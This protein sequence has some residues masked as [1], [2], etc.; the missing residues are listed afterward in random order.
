M[1]NIFSKRC[2]KLLDKKEL[3]VSIPISIRRSIL[4]TLYDYNEN[5]F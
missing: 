4:K 3:I 2:K 1:T 5:K